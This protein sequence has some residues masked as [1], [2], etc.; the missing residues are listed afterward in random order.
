MS[1]YLEKRV[2][3]RVIIACHHCIIDKLVMVCLRL[4]D[5]NHPRMMHHHFLQ[6][7][8]TVKHAVSHGATGGDRHAICIISKRLTV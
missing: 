4:V 8:L 3:C 6:M 7:N 1:C 5:C 2:N